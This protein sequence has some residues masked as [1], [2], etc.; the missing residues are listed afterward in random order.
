MRLLGGNAGWDIVSGCGCDDNRG[1]VFF[2]YLS[3]PRREGLGS[4]FFNNCE[5]TTYA[6]LSQKKKEEQREAEGKS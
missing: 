6:T 4:V 1:C 5:E 3:A 2:L